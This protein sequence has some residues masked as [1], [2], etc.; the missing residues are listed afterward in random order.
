MLFVAASPLVL[1]AQFQD[2]TPDELKMTSDPKAPGAPAVYLYREETLN[3]DDGVQTYYARIKVL[4]EKGKELAS[5]Q[6]PFIPGSTEV[7]KVD[8]RTIHADGAVIPLDVK[9]QDLVDFRS[10]YFRED[11]LVFTL[12]DVDVGCIL[13]YRLRIDNN[14][15]IYTPRW[16]LQY[17]YFIHKEHF[18]FEPATIHNT[19]WGPHGK[20]LDR[21]MVTGAPPNIPAL[22]RHDKGQFTVDLDDV[23]PLPD[24]DWMPP[25]NTFRWRVDFYYTYALTEK[26]FWDTEVKFWAEDLNDFIKVTRKIRDAANSLVSAGD[27]DEQKARKIY[28]AVVK[29]ENTDFTRV[30]SKAELKKEKLKDVHSIEDVWKDQGGG[31]NHI[32][33]LYVALAQAAGLKAWPMQVVDRGSAIFDSSYLNK[34]QLQDYIAIIELGGKEVFVDPGQKVCPFGVLQW[35]HAFTNGFR[36]SDR[37][38]E[39]ASTPSLAYT[40]NQVQ[41]AADVTVDSDGNFKGSARIVLSGAEAIYW[42]QQALE[43]DQDALKKKFE[44]SLNDELPEGVTATLDHFLSL[45]DPEKNLLAVVNLG[46]S[47]GTPAGKR[48]ILPGLIFESRAKHPFVAQD[49]RNIP[50]DVHYPIMESDDVIYHLP[51]GYAVE[52]APHTADVT[53]PGSALLRIDSVPKEDKLEVMRVLARNFTLL[54]PDTYNDLH[55]FYLK[56]AAADQQQIVLVRAASTK[57]NQP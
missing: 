31:G 42:R 18:S 17:S 38:P 48:L 44:D 39:F 30:K 27:T 29:L 26:E 3:S 34:N 14:G 12:P 4:T 8:G 46:G 10:K 37:G 53:W 1:R 9:P 32:A 50:I 20:A 55:D 15:G 13:E 16:E 25:I 51:P 35:T 57:G 40:N 2:P 24:E 43:N 52:S 54:K 47:L 36:E 23:P 33:L 11:K 5:V 7:V 28:A 19:L 49:K 6:V 41:R 21:L 22:I 56:L 45:D